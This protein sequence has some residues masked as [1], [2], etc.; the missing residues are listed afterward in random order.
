MPSDVTVPLPSGGQTAAR[1]YEATGASRR[2]LFVFAH[3]A[4]AGQSHP[5][6]AAYAAALA[7]RGVDVLTFNFP[8]MNAGR[9]APDRAPVLETCF[10]AVVTYARALPPLAGRSVFIGGKSMGGRMATHLAAQGLDGLRGVIVLGYPLHP[11]G[12]PDQLRVAHLPKITVPLLIVQGERDTFGAPDELTPHVAHLPGGATV[13]GVAGGDHSLGVRGVKPEQ[14]REE[15]AA[16][17][18]GWMDAHA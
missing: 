11:P 5:F 12:K 1:H 2:C 8:Y 14:L 9:R 13:H 15:L 4:G 17:I 16:L 6:M 18:V 10:R 7:A 3:G